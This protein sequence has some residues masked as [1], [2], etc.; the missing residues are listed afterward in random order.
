MPGI[1]RVRS[2]N[3]FKYLQ[4]TG[5]LVRDEQILRR[6]KR[7]AIPPAWT[8]VWICLLPEGH[9][10]AVGRDGKKRKQYTY[11]PKWHEVRDETKYHRM[12]AFG[13]SL[14]R[15]REH[16][17]RALSTSGLQ[18]EKVLATIVRLL[19]RTLIRVGNE[20]YTKQNGSFGLTTMRNRHVD[21]Q[22]GK[23]SFYFRGKSGIKHA[24]SFHDD[25]LAKIVAKCRDLPGY[26]LFQYVDS[27]GQIRSIESGDVNN[28]LRDITD[29]DFSS[30][31]F[32]TWAGTVLAASALKKLQMFA[33]NKQAKKNIMAAVR[34]VAK[35]L[36]NT[37]AVCRKCY[38]HPVILDSY[39]D[40][41]LFRSLGRRMGRNT[42]TFR[43]LNREEAA[44][45]VLL[46]ERLRRDAK[47][48]KETL[49]QKLKKSVKKMSRR[50]RAA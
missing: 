28:F 20:E 4:T 10:Q 11:H 19:E 25:Y 37:E 34:S 16:V 9:L 47:E 3:G 18:R 7:L 22:G 43:K 36:G 46:Q 1:R 24:I 39:V 32:R 42:K 38:V 21:I 27:D 49:E 50:A 33:T 6:I 26:E 12:I 23:V 2:G 44:V 13:K 45:L 17:D 14:S 40:R 15:I 35:R 41:T 8:E 29:E 5:E 31:D 30:K 48:K